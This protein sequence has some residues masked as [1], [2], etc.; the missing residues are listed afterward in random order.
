MIDATAYTISIRR[1]EFDGE[2]CFEACVKELPDLAEYADSYAEAYEL[3]VDAIET[4]AAFMAER[5]RQMPAPTASAD[6]YSGRVTLRLPETLHRN[7]AMKADEEGIS[8]NHLLVSVL[9]AFRGFDSGFNAEDNSWVTLLES[10]NMQPVKS[11]ASRQ[12]GKITLLSDYSKQRQ[13][14]WG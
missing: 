2:R 3:A 8:L 7:L 1:G 10:M 9:S 13:A 5:G 4:T 12:H 6:E 14:S 11:R